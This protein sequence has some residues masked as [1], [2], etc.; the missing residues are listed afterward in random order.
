MCLGA[1]YRGR[2]FVEAGVPLGGGTDAPF[3]DCDPWAAMRA[4][5]RR[6]S[7]GGTCMQPS[8][9]LSPEQALGLFTS[10]L[11]APGLPRPAL[12]PGQAA[13]LVLLDRPWHAARERLTADDVVA[14]LIA[15]DIAWQ[16]DGT[17]R[18]PGTG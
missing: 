15:G 6:R 5:V 13:D 1:E 18:D 7:A 10:P 9:A 4:A 3:G 17:V 12:A 8:E 2:G 11:E 14:T 16:R